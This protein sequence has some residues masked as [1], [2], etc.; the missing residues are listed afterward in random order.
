MISA[1]VLYFILFHFFFI[2]EI[3][4]WYF[5]ILPYKCGLTHAYAI[6]HDILLFQNTKHPLT[7]G[8]SQQQIKEFNFDILF[9]THRFRS[10][11]VN[12][13]KNVNSVTINPLRNGRKT[14]ALQ[15]Q[16]LWIHIEVGNPFRSLNVV[17]IS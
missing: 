12:Q 3:K 4:C 13:S 17:C 1:C 16:M 2:E 7:H 8:Q 10:R 5:H 9:L 14:S 6:I 11:S 15:N